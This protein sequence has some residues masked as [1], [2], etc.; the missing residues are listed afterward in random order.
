MPGISDLRG[1]R[2]AVARDLKKL[3][4]DNQGDKWTPEHND[5]YDAM[6]NEIDV[7]DADIERF[8]KVLDL[9]LQDMQDQQAQAVAEK[10]QH[11]APKDSPEAASAKLFNKW[12]RGG[13][14]ALTAEEWASYRNTMSTTTTT[15]GGYTVASTVVGSVLEA[16]KQYGGMRQVASI[17]NTSTGGPLNFPTS[18][19]TAEVGE[20]LAENAAATDLDVSFGTVALPVYKYSSKVVTCPIELLNDT[21]VN[22]EA[23]IRGRIVQRLGRIQNTHFTVGT[24]TGQP[25][26]VIT[27]STTGKT[28]TTGQTTSVIYDDLV[29]LIHSIDPA[30]RESGNCRWMMHDTSLKVL[31]KIKDTAGRPIW[32][33]GDAEGITGGMPATILGYPYTYNQAMATMAASA[34]S[35][36]FGDFSFYTIRDVMEMTFYRFDDSTYAKKGQVGFLAFLRTGGNFIDV[37]G[38]VKL[39]INSAT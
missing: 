36:A 34:K 8:Q 5:K 7:L 33:P 15:E 11:D 18:D 35:I 1:K 29:D 9:T 2:A 38:A 12:L 19:G 27:A 39:Y 13:D 10:F 26:G 22:M 6:V 21:E 23:F 24:G 37:G 32:M 30:Y 31:R 17:I 20:I 25:N 28:G 16:L 3:V 4:D 14:K